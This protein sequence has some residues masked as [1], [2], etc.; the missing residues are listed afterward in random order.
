MEYRGI[1]LD[2]S[3]M[4]YR[5]N[6]EYNQLVKKGLDKL[7]DKLECNN[8]S[9][10]SEYKADLKETLIDFK[11]GHEPHWI[12]P[13]S[14]KNNRGCPKCS[15]IRAKG[16]DRENK[17]AKKFPSIVKDNKHILLSEYNGNH[18]KVLIDFKCGHEPHWIRASNY[19]TGS[20]C[21]DCASKLRSKIDFIHK[22]EFALLVKSKGHTLLS[23]YKGLS[24]YVLIDFKCGHEPHKIEANSYK[25]NRGCPK[26]CNRK[27]EEIIQKWL[28]ENEINYIA[29]Y[30]LPNRKWR[31]DLFIASK[32][33]IVEVH[34]IQHYEYCYW[35]KKKGMTLEQEQE[36][37]YKKQR[38]AERLGYNYIEVDY[39]EHNPELALERFLKAFSQY[40]PTKKKH[41]QLSLF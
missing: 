30:I 26:C 23:E 34:G 27:G 39:R 2:E 11:C 19:K 5:K 31:Y 1:Q 18:S 37:D 17:A 33:L 28:E 14:Y 41:E 12:K 15:L 13:N 9:L 16:K 8:H 40:S 10:L 25:K 4:L 21:P 29:E 35:H 6:G 36:N 20:R 24:K 38:Y 32:K 3:V 7:A 22:K